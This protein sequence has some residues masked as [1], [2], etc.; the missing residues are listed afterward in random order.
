M[1]HGCYTHEKDQALYALCD[2]C[3][4]KKN[5]PNIIFVSLHL[6]V[7]HLSICCS[8]LFCWSWVFL[9]AFQNNPPFLE[10]NYS[11][12]SLLFFSV[13]SSD[14]LWVR[15]WNIFSFVIMCW[16]L[17]QNVCF[18]ILRGKHTSGSCETRGNFTFKLC[19]AADTLSSYFDHCTLLGEWRE[20]GCPDHANFLWCFLCSLQWNRQ[21][22]LLYIVQRCENL[23]K[24]RFSLFP[25]S[26]NQT[27]CGNGDALNICA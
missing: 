20:V 18:P 6:N 8:C 27:W 3:V 24:R 19:I 13:L 12:F 1:V 26:C 17:S 15:V 16:L 2:W 14:F 5:I 9:P 22:G 11:P 25:V 23:K 4:F 7:S 21:R 10:K